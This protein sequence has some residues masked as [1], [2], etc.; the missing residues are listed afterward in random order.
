MPTETLSVVER[1]FLAE[2]AQYLENPSVAMRIAAA[3][4]KPVEAIMEKFVPPQVNA[5]AQKAL[6]STMA[7]AVK[8]VLPTAADP[9]TPPLVEFEESLRTSGW[10]GFWHK[11]ASTVPAIASG[12]FG[13][14]GFAFELPITT[15]IMFRSI[16]SIA[17]SF[18]EDLNDPAVR[19]ECLTVFSHGG[20]SPDDDAMESAYLTTRFALAAMIQ[21]VARAL[22]TSAGKDVAEALLRGT[23][24]RLA[25]L[26]ATVASR[27]NI[28]VAEKFV[29]QSVPFISMATGAVINAAFTDHFSRVAQYHFG[30]RKLERR[31]GADVVQGIY[32]G[33]IHRAKLAKP[34]VKPS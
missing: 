5:I 19:L 11:V 16:A 3:V 9:G 12:P 14:A 7:I 32:R 6:E 25:A 31:F 1:K 20:P 33:E 18:G 29:A 22:T 17:S 28:V 15:G 27:F 8:S 26:I 34:D 2:A 24:P 21:D 30:I 23:A 4:G 13:M 10:G